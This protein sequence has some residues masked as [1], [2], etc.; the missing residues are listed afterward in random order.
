MSARRSSMRGPWRSRFL[1]GRPRAGARL[2]FEQQP[3]PVASAP[4][5][6]RSPRDQVL[7]NKIRISR[8]LFEHVED[9]AGYRVGASEV[10]AFSKVVRRELHVAVVIYA[11]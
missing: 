6:S 5:T 8:T 11:A 4:G 7:S 2:V 3:R 10:R 1:T 9:E